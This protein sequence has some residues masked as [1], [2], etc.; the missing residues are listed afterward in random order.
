MDKF[1]A[2]F[3]DRLFERETLVVIGAF[4]LLYTGKVADVTEAVT[5]I[6][7]VVAL[8]GGRS[9]VKGKA[10][11]PPASNEVKEKALL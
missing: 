7:T 11:E 6:T 9:Y 1:L 5:L 3:V 8:I 2:D 10:L 4:Y